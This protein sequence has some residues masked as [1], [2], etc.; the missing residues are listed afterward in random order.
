MYIAKMTLSIDTSS[1]E[2]YIL[3]DVFLYTHT[4][5]LEMYIQVCVAICMH[6]D[7]SMQ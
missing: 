4:H 3:I 7:N 1:N 5:H 6:I 2:L